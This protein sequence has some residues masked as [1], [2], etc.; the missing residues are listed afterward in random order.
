MYIFITND[1]L[2]A[3]RNE[4][5]RWIDKKHPAFQIQHI[6]LFLENKNENTNKTNCA[7]IENENTN[8]TNCAGIKNEIQNEKHEA[9]AAT[10]A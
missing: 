2:I 3:Y 8:K 9:A 1:E 10:A 6:I 4:N 5:R 7:G